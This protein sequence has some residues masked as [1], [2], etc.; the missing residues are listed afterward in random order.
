M[1]EAKKNDAPS[2]EAMELAFQIVEVVGQW[3][4]EKTRLRRLAA[5]DVSLLVERAMDR[6][7][8]DA[9]AE[10]FEHM[11]AALRSYGELEF[12]EQAEALA[13]KERAK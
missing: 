4:L 12:A 8:R 9:R 7:R 5:D 6:V 3:D 13:A 10:A 11:G 1:S 2:A